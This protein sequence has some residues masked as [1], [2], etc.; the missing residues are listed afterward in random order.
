MNP[1]PTLP[2]SGD[3]EQDRF[4]LKPHLGRRVLLHPRL[5]RDDAGELFNSATVPD[6]GDAAGGLRVVAVRGENDTA[7]PDV[8]PDRVCVDACS[9]LET[10]S[11]GNGLHLLDVSV[12]GLGLVHLAIERHL[13]DKGTRLGGHL[14]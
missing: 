7:E 2:A 5:P 14:S 9:Q 11:D 13:V 1:Q 8:L 12:V 6:Q 10:R 3:I 4:K